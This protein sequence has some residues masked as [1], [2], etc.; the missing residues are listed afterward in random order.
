MSEFGEYLTYIR[1]YPK[2]IQLL[3]SLLKHEAFEKWVDRTL[4]DLPSL[5]STSSPSLSTTTIA[6][7]NTTT[8]LN[9]QSL[10]VMPVQRIPR[11]ILLISELLKYLSSDFWEYDKIVGV[12]QS[13]KHV[14]L[15]FFQKIILIINNFWSIKL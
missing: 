1:N 11:Y 6:K 3:T 7:Q 15:L 13:F 9:L 2:A 14:R 8:T 4:S 5:S 10:L 12:L